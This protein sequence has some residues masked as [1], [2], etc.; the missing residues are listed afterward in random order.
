MQNMAISN[1]QYLLNHIL[2]AGHS[3]TTIAK[4]LRLR[5][6]TVHAINQGCFRHVPR[7]KFQALLTLYCRVIRGMSLFQEM[8][9]MK[10]KEQMYGKN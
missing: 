2:A 9:T 7:C 5:S 6:K 1:T 10:Q 3:E 8:E 4:L